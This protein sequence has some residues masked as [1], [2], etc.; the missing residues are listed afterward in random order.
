M[1]FLSGMAAHA[2]SL[3]TSIRPARWAALAAFAAAAPLAQAS[4]G[5]AFCAVNGDW[6]SDAL[7]LDEGSV[8][9]LRYEYIPQDQPRAGSKK[10]AVGAIPNHH[11]EVETVNRNLLV[12]YSR[13]FGNGWGVSAQLPLVD[14]EH[15]HIHN[16]HGAALPEQWSFREPG[17]LRVI[18]RYQAPWAHQEQGPAS[19][20]LNFG[21]KLPTGRTGVANASGAVAERSLQPGT[22]TT[23]AIL[24]AFFHRQFMEQPASWFAQAQLQ[25]P[26]NQHDGYAPGAQLGMDVG[27]AWRF[28]EKFSAIAQLNAVFKQRDRGANA[29]PED[30][31]GRFLYLSPGF[32]YEL[33]ERLRLYGFWQQPLYQYVNGLQL[34]A[35]KA[36]VIG[37]ATRF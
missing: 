12:N 36:L 24:G 30:S 23:D 29:E 31:G 5:S 32:S 33:G 20:G 8:L 6:A 35:D 25:A 16:H 13:N 15:S 17:D 27:Y 3:A 19:A 21:L 22:G 34:T 26:L 4:C 7:G 2:A 10:V 1:P 14:R 11:D 18:G 28:T 37:V 9:D